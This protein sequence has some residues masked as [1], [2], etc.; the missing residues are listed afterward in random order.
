MLFLVVHILANLMFA[1]CIR[2]ARDQRYDYL[3]VGTTNYVVAAILALAWWWS[4]GMP[5]YHWSAVVYGAINGFQYQISFVV[6]F[7][8]VGLAGVGISFGII[9]LAVAF[10]TLASIF[11]WGEYPTLPQSV[12]LVLA[13]LA[14][15]LLGSD[16]HRAARSRNQRQPWPILVAS[17]VLGGIGL[18]AAKAFSMEGVPGE[19]PLYTASLFVAAALSATG[20][21]LLRERIGMTNGCTPVW[22]NLMIGGVMGAAN[23]LQI[24][25]LLRALEIL[26][27]TIVFPVSATASLVLT[28]LGGMIFFRERFGYVTSG[29]ILIT[30]L[31][32]VLINVK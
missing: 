2:L 24:I 16:A 15:P 26:P 31:A 19:Q 10:P 13:F 22:K 20:V 7:I 9:R 3:L 30:L 17:I 5:G 4:R 18:T 11:L 14:L 27:G 25:M 32:L 1:M 21:W 12:G 23:L 28:I 6:L 8:I 29:G